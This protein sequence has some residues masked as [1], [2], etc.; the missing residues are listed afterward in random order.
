[1]TEAPLPQRKLLKPFPLFAALLV[2]R[3]G[4]QHLIGT[5]RFRCFLDGQSNPAACPRGG[6]LNSQPESDYGQPFPE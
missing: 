3:I 6:R 4:K 1:M 5:L 2:S